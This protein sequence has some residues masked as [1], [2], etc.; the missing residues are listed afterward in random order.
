MMMKPPPSAALEMV[1]PEFVL[2]L[3][4]VALDAPA[5]LGEADEV[6]DG[7]RHRQGREPILRGLRL[8]PR[9][10]HEHPL[11]RPG[12]RAL[13]I[14]MG[15]PHPQPR[16]AGTHR[17]AGAC[18]PRHRPPRR[19]WQRHRQLLETPGPVRGGAPHARGWPAATFPTLRRPRRLAR[20]PRRRLL[21]HPEDVRQPDRRQRFAK[22]G[23]AALPRTPDHPPTPP[24]L[25]PPGL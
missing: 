1:E 23:P 24:A 12:R 9:P 16:E 20:W 4:I 18:A 3:L 8:V 13:L 19:R 10:L 21:L 5:Q 15:G 6:G 2:E 22:R 14:A 17:P 25:P 7:R 11:L